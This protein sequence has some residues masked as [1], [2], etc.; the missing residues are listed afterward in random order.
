[1][2]VQSAMSSGIEGFHKATAMAEQSAKE[3]VVNTTAV[4]DVMNSESLAVTMPNEL[5]A[6]SLSN[7]SN[8]TSE[9]RS[10]ST[11]VT[12]LN[13]SLVDLKVAEYQAKASVQVIKSADESLGTLLDVTA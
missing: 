7:T 8:I 10:T 1:M 5:A 6:A 9:S 12:D 3:I 11:D 13:Q 4:N 2:E